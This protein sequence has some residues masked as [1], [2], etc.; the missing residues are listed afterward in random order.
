MKEINRRQCIHKLLMTGTVAG[1]AACGCRT[2][3]ITGRKQ[4]L[5][6]PEGKEMSLGSEAYGEV[7]KE[8]PLSENPQYT[9]LVQ[10]V[11][12]RIA[13]VAG[14][15][16]FE[17]EFKTL[18]SEEQNAFCLPGGKV[19]VY[20][21]IL[22]ICQNEAGLAVVMGHEIA[23]ALARHGGER[24]SQNAAVQGVQ[25]AASYILQNQEETKKEM[26]FKAYGMAT[27]YGVLLP[28]SRKHESE[29]D[30][31]GITLMANAGYDPAEA[32][33]FWTRFG[34]AGT[35]EKQPEFLSTHPSDERR[36]QDLEA[37][38]PAAR[39]L[40]EQAAERIGLGEAIS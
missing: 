9:A 29:A 39:T 13:A 38:L 21:G 18:Q 33:K 23:H 34:A 24:M 12:Q 20:E 1:V 11:G 3:P 37:L 30:E 17:W 32:P 25:T 22:P 40:Y 31:I 19:A 27:E 8:T 10:R 15:S 5:I 16:D 28:F 6:Y 4:L 14:R 35:G 7:T 36:S 26:I 2:A